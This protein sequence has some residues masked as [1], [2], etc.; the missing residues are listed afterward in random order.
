MVKELKRYFKDKKNFFLHDFLGGSEVG[1]NISRY[2]TSKLGVYLRTIQDSEIYKRLSFP[3]ILNSIPKAGTNL[4][5]NVVLQLPGTF[6]Q[7]EIVIYNLKSNWQIWGLEA[8][9]ISSRFYYSLVERKVY[10]LLPGKVYVGHN[11]YTS[12]VAKFIDR[13]KLKHI[14]IIRDP[15]DYIVS[16]T[17]FVGYGNHIRRPAYDQFNS[18]DEK[19]LASIVGI[20]EG[21]FSLSLTKYSVP[22]VKILYESYEGWLNHK[23]TLIIRYEDFVGEDGISPNI[24]ETIGRILNYLEV[25]PTNDII[26]K[27]INEGMKPEKSHTFRKGRAGEWKKEFKEI[28]F[29]A[30][31]KIGGVEIL[32]KF[33][34]L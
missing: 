22:N 1:R 31:E 23:N 20:G 25:E 7:D 6:L 11:P 15:R 9:S 8:L 12:D 19:L 16:L 29:E 27:M 28:H 33:G 32:K 24:K 30:F 18:H 13:W 2:M 4:L 26:A 17:Y 10:N 3:V 34:Y 21:K 5:L 14:L